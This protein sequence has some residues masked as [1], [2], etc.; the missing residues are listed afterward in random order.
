MKQ[1][2]GN[3]YLSMVTVGLWLFQNVYLLYEWKFTNF[4][5]HFKKLV[6]KF[7]QVNFSTQSMPSSCY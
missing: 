3:M 4:W 7:L 6:K 2:D 5:I 1:M